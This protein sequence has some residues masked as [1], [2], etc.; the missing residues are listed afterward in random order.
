MDSL[1]YPVEKKKKLPVNIP[2]LQSFPYNLM[3]CM[4]ELLLHFQCH[5]STVEVLS[6]VFKKWYFHNF[7]R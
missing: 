5:Q 7:Y 1:A 3:Y 4:I 2:L 6:F